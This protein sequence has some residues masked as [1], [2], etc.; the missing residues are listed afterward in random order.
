[1]SAAT[2][3][4]LQ[5]P[6]GRPRTKVRRNGLFGTRQGQDKK[7]MTPATAFERLSNELDKLGARYPVLSTNLETT[8]NGRP[9]SDHANPSDPGAACYFQLEGIPHCIACDA[10]ERVADNIAAIAAHIEALRGIDR[11][12][13]STQAEAFSGFRQLEAPGTKSW[14]AVFGFPAD[15]SPSRNDLVAEYH[16]LAHERH[17]DRE[18]SHDMMAELNAAYD[19]AKKEIPR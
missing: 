6:A 17:P 8:L 4:P 2:P 5:W 16:R 18:G 13:C 11:W 10:F 3:Y 9:R 14:R 15:W 12:G 7:R 1:M 19:Q